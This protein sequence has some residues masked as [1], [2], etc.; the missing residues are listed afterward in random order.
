MAN[1]CTCLIL[2]C[3]SK[4]VF[5]IEKKEIHVGRS[6]FLIFFSPPD[7][8]WKH[9]CIL[10]SVWGG[11]FWLVELDQNNY[12]GNKICHNWCKIWFSQCEESRG[13]KS[14]K[15]IN[16][17]NCNS[18]PFFIELCWT[19]HLVFRSYRLRKYFPWSN[20]QALQQKF[21][22]N[23]PNQNS[24]QSF[25]HFLGLDTH[26]TVNYSALMKFFYW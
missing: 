19:R 13:I 17:L 2:F 4:L 8:E 18:L 9:F 5:K 10:I 6:K 26:S 12:E 21:D 20:K 14:F 23:W 7:M 16:F 15:W 3:R 24:Q 22:L 11:W 1:F 25:L